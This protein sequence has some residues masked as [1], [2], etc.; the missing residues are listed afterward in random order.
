[1]SDI[2]QM[3]NQR[4]ER[5]NKSRLKKRH[6]E[7][8]ES[9]TICR[10]FISLSYWINGACL[11]F[12]IWQTI[13]CMEKYINKPQATKISMKKST[14]LSFLDITICGS[15]GKDEDGDEVGLNE[16][17]LQNVCGLR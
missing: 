1:M 2:L 12:V 4:Q 9:K 17:Y 14:D 5:R 13:Q 8:N 11:V 3:R 16:T 6:E 15:F 10:T 7:T